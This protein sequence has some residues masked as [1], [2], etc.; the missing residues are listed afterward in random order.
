MSDRAGIA[1]VTGA[2]GGVGGA[3]TRALAEVGFHVVAT[4]RSA[5]ALEELSRPNGNEEA[6]TVRTVIAD[7]CRPEDRR[8]LYGAVRDEIGYGGL[9]VLVLSHGVWVS[10][11]GEGASEEEVQAV[12]DTNFVSRVL[13][14]R[15]LLPDLASRG[16]QMFEVN[17]TAALVPR[18]DVP[19]YGASMAGCASFFRSVGGAEG[20]YGHVRVC[21]IFLGRTDTRMQ[22]EVA[23][24]ESRPLRPD[25][26]LRPEAV[27]AFVTGKVLGPKDEDISEVVIRAAPDKA[28]STAGSK[29]S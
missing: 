13:L 24:V 8:R 23:R 16:G 26:W 29:E 6:G 3:V 5:D 19:V 20:V 14:F 2:S 27:G 21:S 4:G 28:G 7:L 9:D 11:M 15:E 1:L 18:S 12:F 10:G 17:S 22:E 25:T